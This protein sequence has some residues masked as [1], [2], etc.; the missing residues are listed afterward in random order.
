MNQAYDYNGHV[1]APSKPTKVLRT[2]KKTIHIDSADRDTSKFFTNGEFVAYLPRNYQNIVSV[3]LK[4]ASFPRITLNS[5]PGARAHYYSVPNPAGV[6]NSYGQNVSSATYTNDPVV[7]DK[8]FL[9]DIDGLNK[10]D[11]CSIGASK[12]TFT[13][14]FFA[15]IPTATTAYLDGTTYMIEYNDHT[16]GE[17]IATYSPPIENLD[18]LRIRT[19]LHSQQGN[20]GFI[21]WTT[22]GAVAG[23]AFIGGIAN[24]NLTLEIEY[25]ENAFDDFSSF[26][27]RLGCR[28]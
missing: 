7:T 13:D 12:S 17:N 22:T 4:S 21:Y 6:D 3:R 25:L 8:Y 26:E 24:Y 15:K 18:R 23:S 1:V 16:F 11:E 14:G 20:Q 27:T 10:T 19:R 9:V 2:V 28:N 5:S